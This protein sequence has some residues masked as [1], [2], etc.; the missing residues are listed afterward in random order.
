MDD[1]D[2]VIRVEDDLHTVLWGS[3]EVAG[4][5]GRSS[6]G[7]PRMDSQDDHRSD[8]G[9]STTHRV[10]VGRGVEGGW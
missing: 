8:D 1:E 10:D 3:A 2:A 7:V 6:V 4:L 9:Q 5:G